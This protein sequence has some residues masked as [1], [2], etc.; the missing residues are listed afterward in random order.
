MRNSESRETIILYLL[1]ELSSEE[2][3]H[4][5]E[6]YFTDDRSF[7]RL[8]IVE[9]ELIDR[10][11]R[12][13]LS[14][15]EQERFENYFLRSEERRRRVKCSRELIAKTRPPTSWKSYLKKLCRFTR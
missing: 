12:N 15:R 14:A 2:E 11:T 6:T 3:S 10:Y 13:D 1:G 9:Q 4:Y 8:L 5:E 7:D